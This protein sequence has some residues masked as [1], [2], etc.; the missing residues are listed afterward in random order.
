[1]VGAGVV[2][3]T[4]EYNSWNYETVY[5]SIGFYRK[6]STDDIIV[7]LQITTFI[8]MCKVN[9]EIWEWYKK[10]TLKY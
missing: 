3:I 4:L 6:A 5:Y 1:M 7:C 10:L 2:E 8:V 9:N